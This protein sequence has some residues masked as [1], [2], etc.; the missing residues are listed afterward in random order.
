MEVLNLKRLL[1]LLCFMIFLVLSLSV[2]AVDVEEDNTYVIIKTQGYE[3]YWNKGAQMGY[4]QAFV[5]G[6]KDSI[7]GRAGRAFYHS[8]EYGGAWRDWGGLKEWKLV[9]KGAGK[10]VVQYISSDGGSKEYTCI[11]TYYDSVPYIKHEINV[12]NTGNDALKSFQSGHAPMFEVN[13]L[14]GGMQN[15]AQ[16]F[17]H[18]VYW[19]KDGYYAGIYG[20]DAQEA[21]KHNWGGN[22][23]G[24]MDLVHDNQ[25]KNIKKG[26]THGIVYYVAFGNGGMKEA[27]DLANSVQKEPAGGKAVS[28]EGTLSTTW[29]NI[30]SK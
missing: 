6:S 4:M 9:E 7:I 13:M 5:A 20:P 27:V 15:N 19:M 3:V 17:P 22:A 16:P 29:A 30:K 8:C 26:E 2:F 11:I 10:A 21:R 28:P 12:K 25:G 1:I 18:V 23:N 24:R 14:T